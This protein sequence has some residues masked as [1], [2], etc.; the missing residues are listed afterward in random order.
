[1]MAFIFCDPCAATSKWSG[2]NC[3]Q[4]AA[5]RGELPGDEKTFS[6]F[7]SYQKSVISTC[8]STAV[9]PELTVERSNWNGTPGLKVST[10]WAGANPS[11]CARACPANMARQ[12][13]PQSRRHRISR[14]RFIFIIAYGTV[15]VKVSVAES[16]PRK[17]V[18]PLTL[19]TNNPRNRVMELRLAAALVICVAVPAVVPMLL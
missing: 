14:L 17:D 7:S 8:M 5:E 2:T 16:L 10:T 9:S 6:F 15:I 18:A 13:S 4:L 1:M 12:I 19:E 3:I 11:D